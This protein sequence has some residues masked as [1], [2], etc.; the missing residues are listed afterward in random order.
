MLE[1]LLGKTIKYEPISLDE[2]RKRLGAKGLP[3]ELIESFLAIAEYQKAG[4]LTSLVSPDTERI[5][6]I[7]PYSIKD[8]LRDYIDFF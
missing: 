6:G 1:K 5:L 3:S 4:G 7:T 2:E 8:F